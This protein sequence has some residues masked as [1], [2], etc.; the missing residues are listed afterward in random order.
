LLFID[1]GFSKACSPVSC[2]MR[3]DKNI[4]INPLISPPIWA[5]VVFF[6]FYYCG[7]ATS[8]SNL[9]KIKRFKTKNIAKSETF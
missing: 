6:S 1:K 3:G 8:G 7:L 4:P 2:L 9:Y 5:V